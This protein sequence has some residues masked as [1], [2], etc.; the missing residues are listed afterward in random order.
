MKGSAA[1]KGSVAWL[2]AATVKGVNRCRD[3]T[4][5]MHQR[6]RTF[7][8]TGGVRRRRQ[9]NEIDATL[10]PF[11]L[12]HYFSFTSFAVILVFAVLLSWIIS[13]NA[14]KV[15][16]ERSDAYVLYFAENL[17]DQVWRR[18]VVPTIVKFG[19]ITMRNPLQFERLDNIVKEITR[20]M[21]IDSV[22]IYDSRKNI[23]SYS[24]VPELVGKRD[25]G[26]LE[27]KK[28]L[29]GKHSSILETS[30]SL[31]SLLPGASPVTCK[32]KMS[33]PFRERSLG[34]RQGT[35]MG[36]IEIV[37]DLS[38]DLRAIIQLQARIIFLSLLIM[39]ILF[40]ILSYIV[41]RANKILEER[42][43]EQ[44][45]LEKKLHE[46]ERLAHLG[47]M[48]AGVSH[49]IKNPL[50]IVR[51]T[52]EILGRRISK[53]A[54][55]NEHLAGIIVDETS[56]LDG[57]VRQFLDFARPE[58][59]RPE[60][61]ALAEIISRIIEFIKPEL[62]DSNITLHEK[63]PASLPPVCADPDQL[64]RALLNV[65][66]NAIQAMEEGGELTIGA[67]TTTAGKVRIRIT[68]TGHGIPAGK[69]GQV[70]KPFYTDKHQG[71]G[72]GLA[73]VKNIIDAHGGSI[74]V[75]STEGKGTTFIISLPASGRQ[76]VSLGRRHA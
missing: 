2:V 72:L 31:F 29:E 65:V 1:W 55:G 42:A 49:E 62:E 33:I 38:E 41:V 74:E 67:G 57:I 64:Y 73:I 19:K 30:G 17:N 54:P 7:L 52:A 35:I 34:K 26:G 46:S 9:D 69:I 4:R 8:H 15:L 51:S 11:R 61:I 56:R 13:N 53:V 20:G 3:W 6:L 66:V 10:K 59:P 32:L 75:R 21:R 43:R 24:T 60:D 37:Q 68:D 63:I 16:F 47:K 28:A 22:T 45:N 70:F 40:G 14:R 58:N 48:V 36:V 12:V 50:G 44:R 25:V 5:E 39:G 27:Y 71:T 76:T 23:I 18:F